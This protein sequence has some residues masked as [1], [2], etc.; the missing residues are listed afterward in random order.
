MTPLRRLKLRGWSVSVP[1]Q[2]QLLLRR[3]VDAVEPPHA[4]KRS[5]AVCAPGLAMAT[6]HSC[7]ARERRGL[8]LPQLLLQH[9]RGKQPWLQ[10]LQPWPRHVS[11]SA[12]RRRL[13]P[14]LPRH[15]PSQ[16]LRL[17]LR[18]RSVGKRMRSESS[19]APLLPLPQRKLRRPLVAHRRRRK[20]QPLRQLNAS[21]CG[22][23]LLKRRRGL[24]WQQ[25]M[26][27][28]R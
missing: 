22:A 15:K 27:K 5:P 26:Q 19:S 6:L 28:Q 24:R 23:W 18:R 1:L 2:L 11:G 8:R 13:Q 20:P 25:Q 3:R 10:Q 16:L 21:A 12:V 4:S 14:R 9:A 7:R 17:Q